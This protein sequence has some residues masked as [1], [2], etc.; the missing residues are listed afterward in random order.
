MSG[1]PSADS[2]YFADSSKMLEQV[3]NYTLPAFLRVNDLIQICHVS[4]RMRAQYFPSLVRAKSW[5]IN[6]LTDYVVR[7]WILELEC[8]IYDVANLDSFSRLR[9]LTVNWSSDWDVLVNLPISL[10]SLTL[11]DAALCPFLNVPPS[12]TRLHFGNSC[13]VKFCPFPLPT[14][15]QDIKLGDFFTDNSHLFANELPSLTTL[16]FGAGFNGDLSLLQVPNLTT[17]KLDAHFEGEVPKHL[18]DK[19]IFTCYESYELEW[20]FSWIEY[21]ENFN[22]Q[23]MYT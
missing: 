12:L 3:V 14:T 1:Q 22:S 7:D 20:A 15:L 23:I 17:L 2:F 11:G 19:T 16:E 13:V 18:Q 6:D 4:Q 10:L 5:H 9:H 21:I 8:D